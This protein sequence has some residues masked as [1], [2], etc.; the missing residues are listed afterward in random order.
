MPTRDHINSHNSDEVRDL[1]ER[2]ILEQDRRRDSNLSHK[3]EMIEK[4]F[5]MNMQVRSEALTIALSRLEGDGRTC[6]VRCREQV[7]KFYDELNTIKEKAVEL[8]TKVELNISEDLESRVDELEKWKE[9]FWIKNIISAIV[10]TAA[11][12]T[13]AFQAFTWVIDFLSKTKIG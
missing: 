11:V 2:R 13:L 3:L 6:I 9:N 4:L 10:I 1:I 12:M 8:K 7:N 5:N